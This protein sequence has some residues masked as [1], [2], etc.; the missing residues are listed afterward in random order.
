[1]RPDLLEN[2]L[3]PTGVQTELER[4]ESGRGNWLRRIAL[5]FDP[6]LEPA[7]LRHR[8]E[9]VLMLQRLAM[10]IGMVLYSVYFAHD[11]AT[12]R[13]YVDPYVWGAMTAF[14]VRKK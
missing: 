13:L 4:L 11:F 3:E 12:S 10:V 5:K 7:F 8:A 2:T 1:M 6:K 14:A 9:S